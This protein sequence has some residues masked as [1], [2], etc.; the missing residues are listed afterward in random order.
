MTSSLHRLCRGTG[1]TVA[2]TTTIYGRRTWVTNTT[3]SHVDRQTHTSGHR[4]ILRASM[5]APEQNP[6]Q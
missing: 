6:G 4:G 2:G 1:I 3:Q 5:A